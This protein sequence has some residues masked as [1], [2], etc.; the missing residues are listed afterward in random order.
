MNGE[1]KALSGYV[2][3]LTLSS[4]IC[5]N[6]KIFLNTKLKIFL[7]YFIGPVLFVW[8]SFSIYYQVKEQKDLPQIWQ[9]IIYSFTAEQ[10]WN[11]IV[12]ML[13]MLVNWGLEA[14]KWQWLMKGIQ[15]IS[16]KQSF[17]AIF[18]G[19]AFAFGT[20]NNVGEFIGKIAYLDEGN[21]SRAIAVSIVGSISQVIVTFMMGIAGL[22]FFQ[23]NFLNNTYLLKTFSVVGFNLLEVLMIMCLVILLMLYYKLIWIIRLLERI[24]FV[25]KYIYLISNLKEFHWKELTRIL[26]LSFIRFIVFIIQYLILLHVFKVVADNVALMWVVSVLFLTL[27]I[28]PSIAFAE[29]GLRGEIGIQLIGLLSTNIA[30]ILL[31]TAGIWFIN[32]VLPAM[33]GSIILMRIKIFK[34][35]TS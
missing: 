34:K 6:K 30:G 7:N 31:A 5:N 21:R 2:F 15:Q 14:Y 24:S 18:A 9:S 13:L 4:V 32:R 25:S 28:I 3:Y 35:Q 1:N 22:I 29:L 11:L 26:F 27:A 33:T 16:F 10:W 17:K 20:V 8:L 19:Q 23:S 12:V